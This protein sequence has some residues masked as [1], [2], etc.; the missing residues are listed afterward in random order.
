VDLVSWTSTD[1]SAVASAD[2]PKAAE[3]QLPAQERHAIRPIGL[4]FGLLG[5]CDQR[6]QMRGACP[7]SA[8]PVRRRPR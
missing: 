5:Q 3:D 7:P 1:P 6:T 4:R 8:F 2:Q